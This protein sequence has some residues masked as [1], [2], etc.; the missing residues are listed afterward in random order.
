MRAKQPGIAYRSAA[1]GPL[2][3]WPEAGF[4]SIAYRLANLRVPRLMALLS[5]SMLFYLA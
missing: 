2:G 4:P 3:H 5:A 1:A